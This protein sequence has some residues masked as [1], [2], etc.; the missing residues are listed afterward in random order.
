MNCTTHRRKKGVDQN[1]ILNMEIQYYTDT[2]MSVTSEI[3][4]QLLFLE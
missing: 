4:E 3:V 2:L 1:D